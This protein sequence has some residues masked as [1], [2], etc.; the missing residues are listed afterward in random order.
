MAI[1]VSAIGQGNSKCLMGSSDGML[2]VLD[3]D[4]HRDFGVSPRDEDAAGVIQAAY[5]PTRMGQ[6]CLRKIRYDCFGRGGGSVNFNIY[7]DHAR[8]SPAL[9]FSK[10]LPEAA[11]DPPVHI[12]RRNCNINFRHIMVEARMYPDNEHLY[13][14][15]FECLVMPVGGL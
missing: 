13:V 3:H 14:G 6:Q 12:D 4:T 15:P 5:F 8:N 11:D 2:F 7:K 1:V 10:D 9:S